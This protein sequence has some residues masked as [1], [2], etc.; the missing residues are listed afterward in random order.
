[1]RKQ[2]AAAGRR[3]PGTPGRVGEPPAAFRPWVGQHRG[4]VQVLDPPGPGELV[5]VG[6]DAV[7][8]RPHPGEV[9]RLRELALRLPDKGDNA[10]NAAYVKLRTA[11]PV[12]RVSWRR[13]MLL[14]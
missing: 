11:S 9:E 12:Q 14:A 13:A 1:L 5:H 2:A 6:G 3:R 10:G 8:D 4:G 7:D